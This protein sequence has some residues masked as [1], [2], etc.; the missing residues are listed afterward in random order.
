M[1]NSFEKYADFYDKLYVDKDYGSEV[2]YVGKVIQ[3]YQPGAKTILEFGSGT[4][5]HGRLLGELGYSVIGIEPSETMLSKSTETSNFKNFTGDI[6]EPIPQTGPFDV[7]LVLFHVFNYLTSYED[8]LKAFKNIHSKLAKGGLLALEV[9]HGPAVEFQ[10]PEV[11]YKTVLG[12]FGE[13]ARI[14]IPT[15][16]SR[17]RVD[18]TYHIFHSEKDSDTY[19]KYSEVHSLS[20]SYS[21]QIAQ[22]ASL[23][24]FEILTSQEFMTSNTPSRDS[25]SVLYLLRAT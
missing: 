16:I 11:R 23:S 10:K 13:I 2:D 21:D 9:W 14:A 18:V 25:W 4:G 20:P 8:Q 15:E 3:N 7:C 19:K 6:R 5:I 1:S 17:E 22:L 24:G 12:D